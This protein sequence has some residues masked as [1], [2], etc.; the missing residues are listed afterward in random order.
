MLDL[1]SDQMKLFDTVFHAPW[2]GP[3]IKGP[4]GFEPAVG[5]RISGV[6]SANRSG[7]RGEGGGSSGQHN[8]AAADGHGWPS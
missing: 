7:R 4:D 6:G 3:A 2:Q 8:V 1:L 5:W